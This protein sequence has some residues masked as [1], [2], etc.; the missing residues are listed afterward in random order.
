MYSWC[1]YYGVVTPMVSMLEFY[2]SVEI[3][4]QI[5]KRNEGLIRF[6]VSEIFGPASPDKAVERWWGGVASWWLGKSG[7]VPG[8]SWGRKEA[9][10]CNWLLNSDRISECKR[11]SK[12]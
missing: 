3:Q 6:M 1:S 8:E 2:S 10:R 12:S 9:Q 11:V 5:I 4:T 7:R